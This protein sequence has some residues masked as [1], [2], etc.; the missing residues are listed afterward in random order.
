MSE[1]EI[2]VV[3]ALYPYED[4][5]SGLVKIAIVRNHRYVEFLIE[6]T[7]IEDA[8]AFGSW[9]KNA[10]LPMLKETKR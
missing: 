1:P 5:E 4:T 6:E 10:V 7:F 2:K 8:G 3:D 9:M